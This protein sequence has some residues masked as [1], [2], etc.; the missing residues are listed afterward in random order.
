MNTLRSTT[1]LT[2]ARAVQSARVRSASRATVVPRAVSTT[3]KSDL[4][5]EYDFP[6]LFRPVQAFVPN[7]PAVLV[8][9]QERELIHG[10]WAMLGVSGAWAQENAG[11]GP[12]FNAGLVCTPADCNGVAFP[13]PDGK[14][15]PIAPEGSGYPNFYFIVFLQ[16]VLV[17]LAECYRTGIIPSPFPELPLEDPYPGGRF[18]PM[19]FSSQNQTRASLAG[20][21]PLD[22]LKIKEV[23]HARM[24][25]LAWLGFIVQAFATNIESITTDGQG[26]NGP[27]A[28]LQYHWE[29]PINN[30]IIK[31]LGEGYSLLQ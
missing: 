9:N 22:E 2:G 10:R 24:A 5:P 26:V 18:D 19:G 4:Y 11:K 23:K 14:E 27:I 3:E 21:Y 16:V 25:M 15:F 12:W 29:D 7:D 1:S 31:V 20:D 30:S 13:G 6:A 28:N 17:G 8:K